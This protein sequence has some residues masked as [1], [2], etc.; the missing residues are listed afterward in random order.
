MK[1]KE[2]K[3]VICAREKCCKIHFRKFYRSFEKFLKVNTKISIK[4]S[5]KFRK[6]GCLDFYESAIPKM[7]ERV[8]S[9]IIFQLVGEILTS[10]NLISL[11]TGSQIVNSKH[12]SMIINHRSILIKIFSSLFIE[13]FHTSGEIGLV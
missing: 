8:V 6:S 11:F 12:F 9:E 3:M 10:T 1:Q 4:F 7:A 5:E 13:Y 2:K